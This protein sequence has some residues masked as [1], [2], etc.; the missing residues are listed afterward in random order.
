MPENRSLDVYRD[1][2]LVGVLFDERPL[3]FDYANSWLKSVNPRPITPSLDLNKSSHI[4]D[5]VE[6]YFENL[7]PEAAIRDLLK[8]KYQV[9]TTFGLLSVIGGDTAGALILVHSGELLKAPEY[10]ATTWE[11]IKQSIEGVGSEL[12]TPIR[13][14]DR[15]L[16][17]AGAQ[18][19]SSILIMP[20]GSPAVPTNDMAPTSHILKPDIGA[21]G[22]KIWRSALN[23]T[24]VMQLA[25]AVQID[26]AEAQYQP[27]V[28]AC[29]IKRYD[30]VSDHQNGLIR[31]HQLDL[32]QL[33][34][35]PSHIKY[36]T[37]NGPTLQ[38][39]R[40]LLQENGVP[41]N[42]LIRLIQWVF[43]NLYVG[44]NDSHAKNLSIYFPP[45]EGVRLTPF[46]DLLSTTIYPG[47][48]PHFA[49]KIGGENSPAR[50]DLEAIVRMSNELGFK[51][52][53]VINHSAKLA[54]K[55]LKN[56]DKVANNLSKVAN[57]QNEPILL[58]RLN[59]HIR[60]NT[61]RLQSRWKIG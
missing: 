30:R 58:E 36:E 40:N 61:K 37:D 47:L 31:L 11:E 57:E 38:R 43:F 12:Q 44:N 27:I 34:G 56:I 5:S 13:G 35:K 4:G 24:F 2:D 54:E 14:I 39:C 28:K 10:K 16:S 6:S 48:S 59:N 29:L 25:N 60:T 50:I 23:E 45:N 52:N 9:T 20:D 26:A 41:A 3:R 46:Y 49:F 32:C 7:I 8:V 42:D 15:R 22:N 19:K 53:Y 1:N 17:L 33:D 55:I 18:S 51:P 21:M